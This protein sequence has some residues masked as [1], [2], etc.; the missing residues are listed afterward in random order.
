MRV[1]TKTQAGRLAA[2]DTR[3]TLALHLKNMLKRVDGKASVSQLVAQC[4]ADPGAELLLHE[5][6][7]RHLIEIKAFHEGQSMAS[8][9]QPQNGFERT[10]PAALTVVPKAPLGDAS[11]QRSAGPR[12]IGQAPRTLGMVK[13]LMATFILTHQP[14]YAFSVLKEIE[15]I[16]TIDELKTILAGYA[17]VTQE[18]GQLG[19]TH[20]Y[21]IEHL[22]DS[23][24]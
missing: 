22:V 16:N 12:R 17:N 8:H 6:E 10:V 4:G 2:F 15:D 24:H 18:T 1:Y 13:D 23:A 5:L 7:R 14:R 19:F 9:A 11:R 3:S 20:L 21:E